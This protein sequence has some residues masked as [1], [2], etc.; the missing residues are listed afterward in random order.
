MSRPKRGISSKYG[1][2]NDGVSENDGWMRWAFSASAAV[3]SGDQ[4]KCV[5]IGI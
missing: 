1:E 3:M 5:M 4:A 2:K